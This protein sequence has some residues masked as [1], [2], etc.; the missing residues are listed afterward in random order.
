ML[1]PYERERE[2]TTFVALGCKFTPIT[3]KSPV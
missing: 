1:L 2:V 3:R